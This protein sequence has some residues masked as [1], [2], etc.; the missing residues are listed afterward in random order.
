MAG[1]LQELPR[2]LKG[3]NKFFSLSFLS[4]RASVRTTN[5]KDL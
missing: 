2:V 1:R 3:H 5:L 4:Q